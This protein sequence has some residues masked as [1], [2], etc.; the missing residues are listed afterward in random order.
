MQD[1]YLKDLIMQASQRKTKTGE[2]RINK[3]EPEEESLPVPALFLNIS[4]KRF[5]A[6]LHE[7]CLNHIDS[8]MASDYKK[9]YSYLTLTIPGAA[10]M[11]I[12]TFLR[13]VYQNYMCSARQ[14]GI[15]E[16]QHRQNIAQGKKVA[17]LFFVDTFAP[18]LK[19]RG[20]DYETVIFK[21]CPNE[22]GHTRK[23]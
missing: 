9:I 21:L 1:L 19:Q 23:E 13:Y 2:I 5:Y 6:V 12:G 4:L 10:Q 18:L 17:K 7:E 8:S 3:E 11:T 15:D 14:N 22:E 20:V 16:K